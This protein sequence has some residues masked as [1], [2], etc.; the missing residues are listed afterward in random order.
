MLPIRYVVNLWGLISDIWGIL[1]TDNSYC[2]KNYVAL[3]LDNIGR[4]RS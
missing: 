4:K 2:G 3:A 1:M